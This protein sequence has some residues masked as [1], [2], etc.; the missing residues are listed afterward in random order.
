MTAKTEGGSSDGHH[1]PHLAHQDAAT[2]DPSKL[3]ALSP[4]VVR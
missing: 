4:E 3:T 1:Q 2:V